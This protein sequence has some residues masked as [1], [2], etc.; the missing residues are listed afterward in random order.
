MITALDSQGLQAVTGRALQPVS[1]TGCQAV[2][3]GGLH[4]Y[5][6]VIRLVESGF[7]VRRAIPFRNSSSRKLIA[8][9]TVGKIVFLYTFFS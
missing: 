3:R 8:V 6:R 1:G 4:S 5:N 9:N 2:F 7:K